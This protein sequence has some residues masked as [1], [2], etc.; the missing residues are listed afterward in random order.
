MRKQQKF[1][2]ACHQMQ[3]LG[4]VNRGAAKTSRRQY[5]YEE[6]QEQEWAIRSAAPKEKTK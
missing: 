3:Q 2:D 5:S 1:S 4:D 6:M